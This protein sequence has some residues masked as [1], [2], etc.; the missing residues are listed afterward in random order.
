MVGYIPVGI[1]S[2]H[3]HL[4]R[5]MYFPQAKSPNISEGDIGITNTPCA[6]SRLI[7]EITTPE[8]MCLRVRSKV[9]TQDQ[10]LSYRCSQPRNLPRSTYIVI[11]LGNSPGNSFPSTNCWNQCNHHS[12]VDEPDLFPFLGVL[13]RLEMKLLPA[14]IY[15]E[16]N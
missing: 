1:P 12:Y 7:R 11:D 14:A 13:T 6:S 2:F 4:S 3:K 9:K 5:Y 8:T 16:R 10:I 15:R